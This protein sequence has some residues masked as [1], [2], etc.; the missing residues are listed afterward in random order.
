VGFWR[1]SVESFTG[2]DD[3]IYSELRLWLGCQLDRTLFTL[4]APDDSSI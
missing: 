4:T 3:R 2:E 1:E